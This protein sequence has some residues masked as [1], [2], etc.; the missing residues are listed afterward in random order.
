MS[1]SIFIPTPDWLGTPGNIVIFSFLLS[2]LATPFMIRY[3]PRW[4]IR[5]KVRADGPATH[6]QKQGIPTMG[7][8]LFLIVFLLPL[9]HPLFDT[10]AMTRTEVIF[11]VVCGVASLTG[12]LD[13]VLKM[14]GGTAGLK[15]RYR[16]LLQIFLGSLL[17]WAVYSSG[18]SQIFIP[19]SDS[20]LDI[21]K[22]CIPLAILAYMGTVNGVNFTDGLDGLLTGCILFTLFA[23]GS[24]FWSYLP[25]IILPLWVVWGVSLGFLVWNAYPAKIFMGEVGSSLLG[26]MLASA[27]IATRT[28]LFLLFFGAVYAVEVLSV[29]LQVLSFRLSGKRIFRMSPLH[30]HLELCGMEEPRIVVAFWVFHSLFTLLGVGAVESSSILEAIQWPI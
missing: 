23:Y 29:I 21:G 3:F 9:L 8:V 1:P 27:A 28:E 19:F 11:W 26:A 14:R 5:Q 22:W 10:Q 13:D 17:G 12:L 6:L 2:L 7:G 24:L 25:E 4:G 16:I 15:A 30:H 18:R 20:I